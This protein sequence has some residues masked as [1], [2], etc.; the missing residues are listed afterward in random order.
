MSDVALL[1]AMHG[2][3]LPRESLGTF[4]QSA[5]SLYCYRRDSRLARSPNYVDSGTRIPRKRLSIAGGPAN[6]DRVM[7]NPTILDPRRIDT[8][9]EKLRR[10]VQRLSFLRHHAGYTRV[11]T[12]TRFR[13]L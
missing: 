11:A 5:C 4:N 13:A 1:R 12:I 9:E 2:I 6:I 7:G 10:I 8:A 3:E